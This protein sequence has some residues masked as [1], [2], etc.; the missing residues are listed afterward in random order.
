MH[1]KHFNVAY[2]KYA[3]NTQQGIC[4]MTILKGFRKIQKD[5]GKDYNARQMVFCRNN[6]Y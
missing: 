4:C 3:Y 5:V 2:S 1:S 6:L